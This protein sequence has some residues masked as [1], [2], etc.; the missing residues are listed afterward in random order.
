MMEKTLVLVKPDALQRDLVGRILS[1]IEEKGLQIVGLKMFVFDDGLLAEHY[2]HLTE[3]PFF[4]ELAAYMT[5]G[6]TIAVCVRGTD[7][8][9]TVRLLCGVTKA[10]EAAPGT[11]RGDLAMSVQRNLVHASDSLATAEAEVKRFFSDNEIFPYSDA[12]V[13]YLYSVP[14]RG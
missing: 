10:R 7:A 6:P 2:S 14:E 3:Q 8:V 13:E 4:P 1:R 5:S 11:I 12:T 9:A